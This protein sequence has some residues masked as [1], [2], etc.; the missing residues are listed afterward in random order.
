MVKVEQVTVIDLLLKKRTNLKRKGSCDI[1]HTTRSRNEDFFDN[2][3]DDDDDEIDMNAWSDAEMDAPVSDD[4]GPLSKNVQQRLDSK[5]KKKLV[6]N[7]TKSNV[8]NEVM[9]WWSSS[10]SSS[11]SSKTATWWD[12]SVNKVEATGSVVVPPE[13]GNQ[14]SAKP[15]D[16][17]LDVDVEE[18]EKQNV[19]GKTDE[20]K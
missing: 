7:P 20:E 17:E 19:K 8:V 18:T 6:E 11:S 4:S 16:N 13:K 2:D 12:W 1:T 14:S 10:W 5:N 9:P 3:D 15:L